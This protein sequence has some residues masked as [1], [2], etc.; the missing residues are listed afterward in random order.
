MIPW[1]AVQFGINCTS[2][3]CNFTRRIYQ[4]SESVIIIW[5]D[6][7][8]VVC[9]DSTFSWVYKWFLE[10]VSTYCRSGNFKI[11]SAKNFCGVKFIRSVRSVKFFLMVDNYSM[12][13]CLDSFEHLVY[14]QVS[15]EPRIAGC[16]RRLNIYLGGCDLHASLFIDRCRV[17]LFFGC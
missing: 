14:Y 9:P 12:E 16:S 4:H 8:L 10:L 13:E 2:K 15:A 1:L 6:S 17:I 7:R 3:V 5:L 11:I